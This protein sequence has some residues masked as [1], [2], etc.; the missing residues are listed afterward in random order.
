M[1]DKQLFVENI[2]AYAKEKRE[3]EDSSEPVEFMKDNGW[4]DSYP[5]NM[6][7]N[8]ARDLGII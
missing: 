5:P 4:S 8:M 2:K 3:T 7:D 1:S 6:N